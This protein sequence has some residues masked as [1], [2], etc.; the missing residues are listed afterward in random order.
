MLVLS[1]KINECVVIGDM[2]EVSI[3]A[4]SRDKVKLG[5]TAP[6]MISVHR[7]EVYDLIQKENE[8]ASRETKVDLDD[9]LTLL[10]KD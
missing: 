3:L 5:F 1:R 7:K 4:I 6:R 2:V 8:A 10:K 9:L